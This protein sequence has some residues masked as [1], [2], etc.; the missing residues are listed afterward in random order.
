MLENALRELKMNL[1]RRELKVYD[2]YGKPSST[3]VTNLMRR[4]LKDRHIFSFYH[5]AKGIS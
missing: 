1:M 4:E 3:Q 5:K 2:E